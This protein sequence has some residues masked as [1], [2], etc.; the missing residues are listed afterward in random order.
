M[1]I[2]SSD[3]PGAAGTPILKITG[4]SKTF[5]S[6]TPKALHV[7]KGIDLSV[8]SGEVLVVIGPSGSGKSSL[9]RCINF[10]T[11]GD[12]GTI[13]FAGREWDLSAG[14]PRSP[15]ARASYRKA[16]RKWRAEI[17][18]VFQTFNLFPHM[19]VLRNIA[20][21]P[22]R[23]LGKSWAEGREI[24]MDQLGRLGLA[25]KAGAY[26][27][28]LSGGQKQRVAIARALAM[29]PRLMLFDEATSALDPELVGDVLEAMRQLA[30]EGMT[31]IVVTHE[32]G[33]AR[34]VGDRLVF[35]DQGRIVEEGNPKEMIAA[36][37]E[38]RTRAFLKAVL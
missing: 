32:M 37:R 7:L 11:P 12:G 26:P 34:E 38:E 9:L 28:Q 24:A 1:S 16:L 18:M 20:L 13:A 10:I 33:F 23:V 27:E 30:E 19:T 4:L 15:F 6:R 25:D 22:V 14:E 35:M 31:M 3:E 2:S 17:G 21:A 5:N 29:K 8:Q 36:P